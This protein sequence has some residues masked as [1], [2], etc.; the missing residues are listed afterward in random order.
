VDLA[1]TIA[2]LAGAKLGL[3]PDGRSFANVLRRPGRGANRTVILESYLLRSEA[4]NEHL[5]TRGEADAAVSGSVPYVNYT[6][7]RA[8]RYKYISYEPGG[9]ELYDLKTDPHELSNKVKSKRYRRVV[10]VMDAELE[11][12]RFCAGV[13]CRK[14]ISDLPRPKPKPKPNQ[15]GKNDRN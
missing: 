10:R 11:A 9:H 8:G 7:L 4:L 6:G 5:G 12:R 13:E 3:E 15:P 1:P 2:D 14:G